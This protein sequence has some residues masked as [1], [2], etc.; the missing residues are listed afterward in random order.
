ML[1]RESSPWCALAMYPCMIDYSTLQ[2][3]VETVLKFCRLKR[4]VKQ[5]AVLRR[6]PTKLQ[7]FDVPWNSRYAW[8]LTL[9]L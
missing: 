8:K 4:R 1:D 5:H 9:A 6:K 3:D 7:S 2:Q